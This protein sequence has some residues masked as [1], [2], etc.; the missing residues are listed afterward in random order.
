M[1][2]FL[3]PPLRDDDDELDLDLQEMMIFNIQD[4]DDD[5][6]LNKRISAVTFDQIK[7]STLEATISFERPQDITFDISEPDVMQF[8][9]KT[10]NFLVDAKTSERFMDTKVYKVELE[11]QKTQT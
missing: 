8:Y 11:P 7:D 2:P 6:S 4:A 3:T 9:F 1:T 10:V 5:D